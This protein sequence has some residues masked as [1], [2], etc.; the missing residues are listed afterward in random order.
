MN[1]SVG[2]DEAEEL[3]D[4]VA[5]D[6]AEDVADEEAEEV[7]ATEGPELTVRFTAVPRSNFFP[8][9]ERCSSRGLRR[10]SS[11]LASK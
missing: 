11:G 2:C 10:S 8:T 7:G 6:V 3:A 9:F 5:E 4:D 1:C